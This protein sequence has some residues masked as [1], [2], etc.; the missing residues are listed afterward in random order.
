M[1][2]LA[3]GHSI[4]YLR[5]NAGGLWQDWPRVPLPDSRVMVTVAPP[6]ARLLLLASLAWT[7][8]TCVDVPLAVMDALVGVS[9]DWA[10]L[11]GPG[12]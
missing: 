8:R 3:I 9:V 12:V 7:V 10:A 2:C 11:A 5:E 4:A 1:H 6:V